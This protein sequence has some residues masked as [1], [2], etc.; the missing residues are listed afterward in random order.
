MLLGQRNRGGLL[1]RIG[2]PPERDFK[3]TNHLRWQIVVSRADMQFKRAQKEL[4]TARDQIAKLRA[5]RS[6]ADE[7]DDSQS[8]DEESGHLRVIK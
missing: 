7:Q 4:V 6:V 2:R 3:R 5:E 1:G 8:A